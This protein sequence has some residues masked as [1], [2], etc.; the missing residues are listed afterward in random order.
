MHSFDRQTDIQTDGQTAF[1]WLDRPAFNA[2]FTQYVVSIMLVRRS[3]LLRW[4]LQ[5]VDSSCFTLNC[6]LS[7]ALV[8]QTLGWRLSQSFCRARLRNTSNASVTDIFND[9]IYVVVANNSHDVLHK[10]NWWCFRVVC[11]TGE[12]ASTRSGNVTV[13]I[14]QRN[15]VHTADVFMYKVSCCTSHSAAVFWCNM[16]NLHY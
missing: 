7:P 8:K 16:C 3:S 4:L 9:Y 2:G 10:R 12:A 14:G 6:L 13:A 11:T 5:L 1:S 15:A